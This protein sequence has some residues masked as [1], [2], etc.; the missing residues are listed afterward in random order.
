MGK[1]WSYFGLLV[2]L[3]ILVSIISP[4]SKTVSITQPQ[5]NNLSVEM[6]RQKSYSGSD[7]KIE[8]ILDSGSNYNRYITSYR[9]NLFC[10]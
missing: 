10:C 3:I 9:S 6:M 7:I 4:R 2:I 1:L 5:L 8:Q